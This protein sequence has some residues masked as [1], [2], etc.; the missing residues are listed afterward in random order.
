[1]TLIRVWGNETLARTTNWKSEDGDT[2]EKIATKLRTLGSVLSRRIW[3]A[4]RGFARKARQLNIE[5]SHD[6]KS[7]SGIA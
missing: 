5:R 2:P 6:T 3:L 1:M 4:V 7:G